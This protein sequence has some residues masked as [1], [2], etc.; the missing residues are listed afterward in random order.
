MIV[1]IQ[2]FRKVETALL[3]E[4]ANQE[5]TIKG[6]WHD[7]RFCKTFNSADNYIKVKSNKLG[8]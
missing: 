4:K 1:I 8:K 2:C 6:K 5:K 7:N 3:S